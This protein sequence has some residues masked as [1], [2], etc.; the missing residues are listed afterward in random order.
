MTMHNHHPV[1][2]L[3]VPML[4]L[5]FMLS[6]VAGAIADDASP[7][8]GGEAR[9]ILDSASERL[10][11]T[12]TMQ[13][14][15]DVD[16][17]SYIDD[18]NTMRIIAARGNLARPDKVDVEFQINLLGAQN[19]TIR[20]ITIGEEAWTTDLLTG[21]WGPAPQE[22][23]YNPGVLFDNQNGLGPVA[24][25]LQDPTIE[26]S[27]TV[28]GRDAWKI[29]GTVDETTIGPLTSGVIQGDEI[30]IT[31]WVD[32]EHSNILRIE[33]EEPDIEGKENPATWTMTLTGHD[34][35]ITIEAPDLDD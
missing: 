18:T 7:A 19:V 6:A 31:I 13:F 17:D 34:S 21:K 5:V 27:E 32:K 24:G 30:R 3:A 25:R 14:E 33:I 28:G 10:A 26:G 16:G 20:M 23:G 4:A 15:L 8:A 29:T 1:R 2:L 12:Q 9:D 35:D 22:F 11:D